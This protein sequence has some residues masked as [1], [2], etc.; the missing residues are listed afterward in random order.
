MTTAETTGTIPP[1]G[2][3]PSTTTL[4]RA[5]QLARRDRA[6]SQTALGD[7]VGERQSTISSWESGKSRPNL[8]QLVALTG[9]LRVDRTALIDAVAS[10]VAAAE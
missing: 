5:L 8:A 9:A 6:L 1:N 3:V 7:L 10:D 2:N 4:G